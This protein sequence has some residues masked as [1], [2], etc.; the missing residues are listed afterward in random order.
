LLNKPTFDCIK[1]HFKKS[2]IQ[3]SNYIYKGA[4][5][6]IKWFFDELMDDNQCF[7]YNGNFSNSVTAKV[8]KIN[9]FGFINQDESL[10]IQKRAIYLIGECFQNIIKHGDKSSVVDSETGKSE[11][12]M[13]RS[14]NGRHYI[15]TGNLIKNNEIDKLIEQIDYVNKLDADELKSLY[16]QVIKTGSISDRGG[17]GLG[18]I[19]MAR[20]SDQKIKYIFKEYNKESS[21]FYNQ[22]VINSE[23]NQNSINSNIHIEI[24]QAINFHYKMFD[25]NIL[26]LHKGNFSEDS[27]IPVLKIFENNLIAGNHKSKVFKRLYLVLVE[28]LQ[29]ISLHAYGKPESKQGIFSVSENN[30]TYIISTGNYIENVKIGSLEEHLEFLNKQS[31][32][33]LH[34]EYLKR[35]QYENEK[36]DK[37]TGMG[38]IKL[39]RM[40]NHKIDFDFK[41][42]T[43]E[44]SFFSISIKFSS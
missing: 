19:D 38:L 14:S 23:A 42:K 40:L 22:V 33:E 32:D 41:K 30:N 37:A 2:N 12:F 44:L 7:L 39:A 11:F 43:D 5:A 16:K 4:I 24:D 3:N 20:K 34:K 35:L 21:V 15:T 27:L 18:I 17:A 28:L 6:T 1:N 9:E 26:I 8:L 29:N 36:T 25:E 31:K 10:K 13:T